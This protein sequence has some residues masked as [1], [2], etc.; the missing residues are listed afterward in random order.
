MIYLAF[1]CGLPPLT[2][3]SGHPPCSVSRWCLSL[4]HLS[5]AL[6][7][8]RW[9]LSS[10]GH[11]SPGRPATLKVHCIDISGPCNVGFNRAIGIRGPLSRPLLVSCRIMGFVDEAASQGAKL[12][13]DGR[14]WAKTTPGTWFGPTV[15][16]HN[17]YL[18]RKSSLFGGLLS[19]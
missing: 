13:L 12:L 18:R 4:R 11:R 8:G 7:R 19:G 1:L 2:S 3:S 6:L 17:R 5:Q 9:A 14:A 16:L 15:I 10:I